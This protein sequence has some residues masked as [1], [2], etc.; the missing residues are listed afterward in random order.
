MASSIQHHNAAAKGKNLLLDLRIL[1]NECSNGYKSTMKETWGVNYQ[2]V[3]PD[4]C[5]RNSS[6]RAIRTFK[7][8]FL[9]TL[10]GVGHEFPRHIW[11]LLLPQAEL[12]LNLLRQ[13]IANPDMSA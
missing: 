8:H 4:I 10:A 13:A 3:L 11:D 5:R 12:T 9:A 7:A 2:L 1:D 6:K